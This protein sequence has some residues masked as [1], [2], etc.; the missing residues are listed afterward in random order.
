MEAPLVRV[1]CYAGYRGEQEPKRLFLGKR[2]VEVV[3]ILEDL[4]Q[5]LELREERA[6]VSC[7]EG[8]QAART[9]PQPELGELRPTIGV[10]CWWVD[11]GG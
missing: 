9:V 11:L 6:G 4:G 3:E 2:C 10:L 7:F 8:A 1:D 5:R